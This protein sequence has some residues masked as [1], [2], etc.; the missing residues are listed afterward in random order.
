MFV[1][2]FVCLFVCF[3]VFCYLFIYLFIYLFVCL[4]SCLIMV[5]TVSL[6]HHDPDS[7]IT[8][9]GPHHPKGTHP[10]PPNCRRLC[11]RARESVKL[12]L[13]TEY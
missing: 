3:L 9:P 7:W 2:M 6:M 13:K 1:C 10:K 11:T 12:R 8:D 5:S 4:F